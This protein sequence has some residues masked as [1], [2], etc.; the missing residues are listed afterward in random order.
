MAKKVLLVVPEA[1][2]PTAKA[3]VEERR[4]MSHSLLNG[5]SAAALG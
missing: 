1:P 4:V 3:V 5:E 2:A